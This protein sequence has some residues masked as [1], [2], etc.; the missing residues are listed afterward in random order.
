V[1]DTNPNPRPPAVEPRVC[2]A[3]QPGSDAGSGRASRAG[4]SGG[5]SG[6]SGGGVA[7][8][9]SKPAVSPF[10]LLQCAQDDEC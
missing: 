8:A 7:A 10:A 1:T 6:S 4:K 9:S 3:R 2:S 5:R